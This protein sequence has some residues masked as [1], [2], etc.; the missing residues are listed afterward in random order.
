[1]VCKTARS[2]IRVVLRNEVFM[3]SYMASRQAS[4]SGIADVAGD[5]PGLQHLLEKIY[6][7]RGFDFR[8]YKETTLT[9]RLGRRLRARGVGSYFE[10]ASVLDGDSTEY[11][12]LFKDL[13]INVTSFFRD[14][15]AFRTLEELAL[16]ALIGE[17]TNARKIIRIWSAGCAN[18]AE[19]Y[20]I[21]MLVSEMLGGELGAWEVSIIGTDIDTEVLRCAQ[22]GLF[23]FKEVEEI[24]A[25]LREKYF[26]AEKQGFRVKTRLGHMV[27]FEVH[28]LSSAPPYHDLDLVVCRNLLIYFRPG[29][30]ERVI[31]GLHSALRED[32]FLLLGKAE[33]PIGETKRLF[34]C[35]DKRARLY[36]KNIR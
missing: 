23:S 1:M 20:S 13:T 33:L 31:K 7:E 26:E 6:R 10:Y 28:N 15:W 25:G 29:L 4:F 30:Q 36:R 21:A 17:K 24:P 14:G 35:V 34:Q 16:P 12:N 9:R 19:T 2:E 8:E 27:T 18:G 11:N 5:I 22:E 3:M 32:G